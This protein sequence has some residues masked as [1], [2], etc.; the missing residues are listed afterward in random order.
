VVIHGAGIAI[1]AGPVDRLVEAIAGGQVA[2][3]QGAGIAVLAGLCRPGKACSLSTNVSR[4]AWVTVVAW[5]RIGKGD[6]ARCGV[7][8][9][10]GTGIAI[11]TDQFQGADTGPDNTLILEGTDVPVVARGTIQG[12]HCAL[13][14]LPVTH[15]LLAGVGREAGYR[16]PLTPL[17]EAL[18]VDGAGV[19][20]VTRYA[21]NPL[22]PATGEGVTGCHRARI[23]VAAIHG[24]AHTVAVSTEIVGSAEAPVIAGLREP[25]VGTLAR[26]GC[27]PV[28]GAI[29]AIVT[30][31]RLAESAQDLRTTQIPRHVLR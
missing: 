20:V 7:T 25:L 19:L 11:L 15:R 14:C 17:L 8:E 18:V 9:I 12:R 31:P 23:V 28:I 26:G 10:G 3:I 22:V 29:I 30:L 16:I 13:A 6:A 27:T 5:K 4:R 1:I 21:E 2:G 24:V